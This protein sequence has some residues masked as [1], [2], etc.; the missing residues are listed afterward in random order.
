MS[1]VKYTVL[2]YRYTKTATDVNAFH[3]SGA[4]QG[5]IELAKK[6]G[7]YKGKSRLGADWIKEIRYRVK[8][9]NQK[10]GLRSSSAS[11]ADFV[12]GQVVAAQQHPGAIYSNSRFRAR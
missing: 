7:V 4:P 1:I 11:P 10:A 3:D 9:V 6:A 12:R 5:R 8:P 2:V